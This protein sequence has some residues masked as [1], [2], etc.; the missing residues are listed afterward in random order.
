MSVQRTREGGARG[1]RDGSDHFKNV[2]LSV[3]AQR[4]RVRVVPRS[5]D[6]VASCAP[7]PHGYAGR[8]K[9]KPGQEKEV[10][11]TEN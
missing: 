7:L 9:R 8:G 1:N 2:A 3:S 5:L 10:L 4:V 6:G 11:R